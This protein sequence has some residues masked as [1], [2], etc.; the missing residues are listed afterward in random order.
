M[1]DAGGKKK[2]GRLVGL[3]IWPMTTDWM[4]KSCLDG[5]RGEDDLMDLVVT[6]C[7]MAYICTAATREFIA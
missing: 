7:S 5:R 2:R 4:A 3:R 1:G 6:R